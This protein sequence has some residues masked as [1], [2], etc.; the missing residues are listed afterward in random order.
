MF[1]PPPAGTP[2]Q[3]DGSILYGDWKFDASKTAPVLK[4]MGE[5]KSVAECRKEWSQYLYRF[6]EKT[7][8]LFDGSDI[9]MEDS[10]CSCQRSGNR[11]SVIIPSPLWSN[12]T[13]TNEFWCD[14]ELLVDH[15]GLAYR[16]VK[17]DSNTQL[18]PASSG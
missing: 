12:C 15:C 5:K 1:P 14:G 10:I 18:L 3:A 9:Y 6:T 7:M 2:V 8:T 11:V 17:S 13:Q 4:Q 16:R